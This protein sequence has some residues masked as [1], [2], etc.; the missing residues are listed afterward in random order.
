MSTAKRDGHA[1]A[2]VRLRG[3]H[4]ICLQFYRG[5][6]YSAAFVDNL[7]RV[8]ERI[9]EQPALLV[10]GADDVC[11]ACPGLAADGSCV[12]P[13]AGEIE[14]R[15]IDRLAWD[16]LGAKPGDP[17]SLA[18]AR[19]LLTD[20]AISLGRW[21]FEACSGCTWEDVCGSG[22][23]ALIRSAEAEARATG[24]TEPASETEPGE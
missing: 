8:V 18:D 24:S 14:V 6:G 1:D 23:G 17:L 13:N 12:D 22:W 10:E 11:A 7:T 21:R 4:F 16:V 20:D 15:R 9:A 3:H 2:Q 19:E 5:E